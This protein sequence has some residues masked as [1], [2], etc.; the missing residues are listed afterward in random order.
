M[1][2]QSFVITEV[3]GLPTKLTTITRIAGTANVYIETRPLV[4]I[5][6]SKSFQY[7]ILY[8]VSIYY[9]PTTLLLLNM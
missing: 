6:H 9:I 5:S 3:D 1:E 8:S 7:H 2:T 4:L